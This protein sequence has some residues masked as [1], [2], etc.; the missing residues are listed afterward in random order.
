M[1]FIEVAQGVM[2]PASIKGKLAGVTDTEVYTLQ[3]TTLGKVSEDCA[4]VGAEF[5]PLDEIYLGEVNPN[6]DST[7]GRIDDI[8]ISLDSVTME[9][10]FSQSKLLLNMAGPESIVGKSLTLFLKS[11]LTAATAGAPATP[12]ACCVLGINV[13]P[14]PVAATPTHYH[15]HTPA[16][17][18]YWR[19]PST[20]HGA[21]HSHVTQPAQNTYDQPA[22]NTQA[23]FNPWA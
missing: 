6:Q 21:Q 18:D 2:Q 12:L 14:N 7:R 10:T 1:G 15:S 13:N 5:N 16:V 19:N 20:Y 11:D 8:T 3:V 9:S 23:H 22:Y 4:N 17:H